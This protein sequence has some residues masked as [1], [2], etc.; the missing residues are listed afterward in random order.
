M[1]PTPGFTKVCQLFKKLLGSTYLLHLFRAYTI[2]LKQ[3]TL[4]FVIYLV[5]EVT[6]D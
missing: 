3:K 5:R 2:F 6:L 4:A 1:I